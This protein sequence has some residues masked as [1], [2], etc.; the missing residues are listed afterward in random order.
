MSARLNSDLQSS[1]VIKLIM[2]V[3]FLGQFWPR[4]KGAMRLI[5]CEAPTPAT[6]V[7]L[8]IQ[9]TGATVHSPYPRRLERLTICRY[10]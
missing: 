10:K 9:E 6:H 5:L 1:F 3:I 7:T 8:R 4:G 2:S